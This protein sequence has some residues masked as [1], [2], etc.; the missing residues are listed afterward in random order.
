MR[1]EGA[2]ETSWKCCVS[3]E[4]PEGQKQLSYVDNKSKGYMIRCGHLLT[5][6]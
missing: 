2:G 3:P 4:M 1:L 5:A 6:L